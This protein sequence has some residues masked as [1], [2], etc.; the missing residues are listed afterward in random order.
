MPTNLYGTGDNYDPETS[1]VLP[2][3]IKK[4]CDAKRNN[5]NEVTCWGD[6]S[7]LREFLHCDDLG[8]ACV[9]ILENIS[10]DNKLLKGENS[11]YLGIINI[12]TG[13]D[14]TIRE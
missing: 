3:L 6:G 10:S 8:D 1:H 2:A 4:F 5:D 14:I 13:K 7:P 11:E 9:F 12:G